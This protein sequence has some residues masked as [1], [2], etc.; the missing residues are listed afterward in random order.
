MKNLTAPPVSKNSSSFIISFNIFSVHQYQ[1]KCKLL[2]L[3]HHEKKQ[4]TP[5][6]NLKWQPVGNQ[7]ATTNQTRLGK[8]D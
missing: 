5:S 2:I 1:H 4:S 7:M 6:K 3:P 8:I